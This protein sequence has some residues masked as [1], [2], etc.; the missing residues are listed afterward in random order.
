M[1]GIAAAF[2]VARWMQ[3]LLFDE[4]ARDPV[5]FVAVSVL[6]AIVGV[7][8]SAG[9]PGERHAPIR[10]PRSALGDPCRRY[11]GREPRPAQ[12]RFRWRFRS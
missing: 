11:A 5:V 12:A 9:P 1:I 4:S 8:G 3:P 6:V 2:A 10:T 7:V